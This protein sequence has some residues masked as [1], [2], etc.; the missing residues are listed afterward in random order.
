[1]VDYDEGIYQEELDSM[2]E[3]TERNQNFRQEKDKENGEDAE[4]VMTL[5]ICRWIS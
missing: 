4:E 2:L 3:D 5:R 1:M